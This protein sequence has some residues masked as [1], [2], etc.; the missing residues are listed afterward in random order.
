MADEGDSFEI[1]QDKRGAWRWRLKAKDGSIVGAASEGYKSRSDC[2]ANMKRGAK[3]GDKWEFYADKRGQHRWR[4][5]APNGQIVGASPSGFKTLDM[6]RE[7][8]A[9]HGFRG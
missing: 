9:R 7:N 2:E 1:Y 4:Q 3:N 5:K 8:A 6:A